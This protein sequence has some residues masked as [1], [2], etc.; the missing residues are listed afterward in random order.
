MEARAHPR[1]SLQLKTELVCLSTQTHHQRCIRN[2][3]LGGLFVSGM[4]C[5]NTGMD[6]SLFVTPMN[7]AVEDSK[8]FPARIIRTSNSGFALKFG[9]IS[10]SD[11]HVLDMLT[12]PQW[13]GRNVFDGLLIAAAR[14]HVMSLSECLRLTSVVCND[15]RRMRAVAACLE[16][17]GRQTN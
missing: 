3:S 15:Y 12:K 9:E 13:D 7:Q 14:E 17:R 5:G 1:S 8:C 11:N 10:D 4:P 2:I 16:M 6:V